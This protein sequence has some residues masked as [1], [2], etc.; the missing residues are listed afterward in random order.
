VAKKKPAA[1]EAA[2]SFEESLAQLEQLVARL[3]DGK[4]GLGEALKAYEQGVA[5]L[6]RCYRVLEE[7]E[8]RIELVQA[9][10][11]DG[12]ARTTPLDDADEGD[13]MEKS[14]ARSRRRSAP[15]GPTEQER[16]DDGAS[17]F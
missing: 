12:Q 5:R 15:G 13:L 7:V 9:V 17:L 2:P 4:L 8:R 1:D 11:R 16:V 14:A 6:H 3:E 10:D